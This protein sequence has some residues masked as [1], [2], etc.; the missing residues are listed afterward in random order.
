MLLK[1]GQLI[2]SILS[3]AGVFAS[4]IAIAA[5]FRG[6]PVHDSSRAV[7]ITV[8]IV[9]VALSVAAGIVFLPSE[10]VVPQHA[11][12]L[13]PAERTITVVA[14]A[15]EPEI[16][17]PPR[18]PSTPA[19]TVRPARTVKPQP[20]S[21]ITL[22]EYERT[23]PEVVAAA[24]DVLRMLRS[25]F[26]TVRGSLRGRQTEADVTLQGLITTDLTLDVKLI[27]QEGGVRDAFTITSRGGGFTTDASGLQAR[28]RLRDALR[29]RMG[30]EQQ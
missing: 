30:K 2:F 5:E 22:G 19:T 11:D 1:N 26:P 16:A 25:Q 14:A 18:L 13:A 20:V 8:A 10:P 12:S 27:D 6:Q 15:I 17:V 9:F 21:E 28:E 4:I 23:M 24:D 7:R 3:T 29:Q